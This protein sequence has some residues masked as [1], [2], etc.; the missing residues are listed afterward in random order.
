MQQNL[1]SLLLLI[2]KGMIT[3]F[4]ICKISNFDTEF[5]TRAKRLGKHSEMPPDGLI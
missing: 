1:F 2:T 3:I 4:I 5:I